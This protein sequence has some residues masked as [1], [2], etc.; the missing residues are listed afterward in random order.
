MGTRSLYRKRASTSRW[1]TV[2][3]G[4][5]LTFAR[6]AENSSAIRRN[7]TI[8][9]ESAKGRRFLRRGLLVAERNNCLPGKL[10]NTLPRAWRDL[11]SVWRL[12]GNHLVMHA[13]FF[14]GHPRR[15]PLSDKSDLRGSECLSRTAL[16]RHT[17]R[18]WHRPDRSVRQCNFTALSANIPSMPCSSQ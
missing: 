9:G 13:R 5:A 6:R 18:L 11:L 10:R 1:A 14:F 17:D 8:R 2:L 7:T 3:R 4:G 12:R 15:K 16:K